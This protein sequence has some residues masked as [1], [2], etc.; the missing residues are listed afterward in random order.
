MVVV[1]ADE[2]LVTNGH[3]SRVPGLAPE[4]PGALLDDQFESRRRRVVAKLVK[5]EDTV[6]AVDV[7]CGA[8]TC[9]RT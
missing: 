5:L 2:T 7:G 9:H 8:G 4:D 1:S 6:D 3:V